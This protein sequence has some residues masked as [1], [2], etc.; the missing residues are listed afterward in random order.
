MT[1]DTQYER[2]LFDAIKQLGRHWI[3]CIKHPSKKIVQK[4]PILDGAYA[5]ICQQTPLLN[6]SLFDYSLVTRLVWL[7]DNLSDFPTCKCCVRPISNWNVPSLSDSYKQT[8]SKICERQLAQQQAQQHFMSVYGVTN[9][10]QLDSVKT[11][12]EEQKQKWLEKCYL[13]RKANHT[14]KTSKPEDEAYT[15]LKAKFPDVI[16]QHRSPEYPFFC[17]F[18]IPSLN[19]YIECNFSWTHGGSPYVADDPVCQQQLAEWQA[20][21]TAYYK[22]AIETWTVRDAKKREIGRKLNW[23]EFW[24]LEEMKDC[25]NFSSFT[26]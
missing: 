18:Y 16:R 9:A 26:K 24:T 1:R 13:A 21:G 8:C 10:F 22:N 11:K 12:N 2:Q 17:D 19:L 15:L 23:K 5:Y 14:F 3:K 25:L 6:D 7:R 20:K 4:H